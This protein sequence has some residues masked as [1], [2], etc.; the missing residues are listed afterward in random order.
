MSNGGKILETGGIFG[1]I[2]K[3]FELLFQKKIEIKKK[4]FENF[5]NFR[6]NGK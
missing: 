4:K 5:E 1:D 3:I 6:N 2:E